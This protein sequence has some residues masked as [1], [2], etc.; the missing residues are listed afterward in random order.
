MV[1]DRAANNTATNDDDT[2]MR[3]KR[4]H[5]LISYRRLMLQLVAPQFI[6]L[7]RKSVTLGAYLLFRA[8]FLAGGMRGHAKG[9]AI[10]R[11][12]AAGKTA[13]EPDFIDSHIRIQQQVIGLVQP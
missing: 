10:D 3:R 5:E 8:A 12:K 7:S 9:A 1:S 11:G 6:A 4:R 13:S 2:R